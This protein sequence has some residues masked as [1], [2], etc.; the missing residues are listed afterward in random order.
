MIRVERPVLSLEQTLVGRWFSML[1]GG[2]YFPARAVG[3]PRLEA[4]SHWLPLTPALRALRL[5]LLRG[6][7]LMEVSD[8]VVWLAVMAAV[9]LPF[10]LFAFNAGIRRARV[11]GSLTHY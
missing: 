2:V 8:Q 1:L 9:L 6:Q 5:M 7:G 11:S 4:F 3:D 10:G